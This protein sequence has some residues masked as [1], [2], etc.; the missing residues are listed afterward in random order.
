MK[1]EWND[2]HD[3]AFQELKVR[4]TIVLVLAIPKS[5]EKFT[6]FNDV[7]YQGL[8]LYLCEMTKSLPMDYS[9][10]QLKANELN[11]LTHDLVESVIHDC[12][13]LL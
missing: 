2:K 1:F 7:F 9:S 4:L 12:L 11:Y 6:I 13:I 3:Y 5:G 10:R 8:G